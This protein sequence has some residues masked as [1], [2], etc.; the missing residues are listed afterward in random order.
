VFDLFHLGDESAIS[1]SL[2]WAFR[3]VQITGHFRASAEAFD[4][5]VGIEHFCTDDVIDFV[6]HNEVVRAR[7]DRVAAAA[8][9][10]F[11]ILISSGSVSARRP[12]R[13]AAHWMDFEFVVASILAESS[14][15]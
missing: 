15:P 9:H 6:E 12:S 11:A 8:Q 5:L 10:S 14:S 7:V 4:D 2:G 13:S 3:P 1:T